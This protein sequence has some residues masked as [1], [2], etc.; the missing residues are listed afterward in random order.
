MDLHEVRDLGHSIHYYE[1]KLEREDETKKKYN[2]GSCG[3][4][5][6]DLQ[7]GGAML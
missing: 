1:G 6:H 5:T 4:Q 2:P 3:I 7:I